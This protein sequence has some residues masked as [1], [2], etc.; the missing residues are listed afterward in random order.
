M[1]DI[2]H[3][4]AEAAQ[5][6]P[7]R[8]RFLYGHSLGGILALNHALRRKPD[9]AGVV[10][11]SPALHTALEAQKAKVALARLLGPVL[12]TV[13]LASG[14]DASAISRDPA[15]VQAYV[16]DPLVHDRTSFGMASSL[17]GATQYA[18]EHASEFPLPLLLVHGTADC[19]A[20]PSSSTELAA[21][22][23]GNCTLKLWDGLYHETHNEPEK[24][25]VLRYT[26]EWMGQRLGK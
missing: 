1:R 4:L 7:G 14:L 15:V 22:F 5:R 11:T 21:A 13:S 25:E 10:A 8:P 16:Q 12:P 24:Q 6:F 18:F 3:L 9:L 19:V 26:I 20:F 23:Q 2:D 17:L